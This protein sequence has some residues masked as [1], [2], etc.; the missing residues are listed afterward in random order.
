MSVLHVYVERVLAGTDP[1]R[2]LPG[3]AAYWFQF[4]AVTCPWR[5]PFC[6]G[7]GSSCEV[8]GFSSLSCDACCDA[9]AACCFLR[10]TASA[11][12]CC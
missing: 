11:K 10:S 6:R 1:E 9:S 12:A 3:I 8:D 5:L 2:E 7:D 4:S